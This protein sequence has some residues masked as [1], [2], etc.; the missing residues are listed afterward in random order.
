MAI[1]APMPGRVSGPRRR[2]RAADL[3]ALMAA[4][5][6]RAS[7]QP[8]VLLAGKFTARAA[9]G[10]GETQMLTTVQALCGMGVQARLWRPWEDPFAETDCLHLFGSE[11]EHWPLV[12]AAR[13]QKIPV[14]ISTIAWFDLASRWREPKSLVRRS[15]ACG[16]FLTRAA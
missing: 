12:E 1:K 11:P 6:D 13:R 4:S 7:Q 15:I 2:L 10:G 14:V 3:P 8:T 16:K 5:K 9:P